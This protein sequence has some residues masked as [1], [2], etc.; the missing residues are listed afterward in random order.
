MSMQRGQ[1]LNSL[2]HLLPEG[3]VVTAA[4]LKEKGYSSALCSKYVSNGWLIQPARGLYKRPGAETKWQH[5]VISMQSLMRQ[6][7]AVGGLSALELQRFGHY[8]HLG[9]EQRIFLYTETR[10]AKWVHAFNPL[11]QFEQ[12]N[13]NRLFKEPFVKRAVGNLPE[14]TAPVSD[15]GGPTHIA[16]GLTRYRWGDREWPMLISSPERAILE[17]LD[18]IPGR[19][20]F[21]HAADIFTGLA[22]LRPRRL[23]GLLEQCDSVKVKR[24]FLWFADQHQHAWL[25]HLDVSAIDLGSGKR[26]IAT[27]GRLDPRYQITVPEAMDAN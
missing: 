19:Q 1:K 16:G 18:E 25:K 23:Q 15:A 9:S 17:F 8:V 7:V 4:W 14:L 26:V 5:L 27:S 2:Q 24:L 10:L 11:I 12:R 6:P 13:A 21:Q 3:M 22:N 20:T